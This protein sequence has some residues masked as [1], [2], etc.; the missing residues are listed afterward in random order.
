MRNASTRTVL[1]A[2]VF[3]VLVPGTVAGL[4]P[5]WLIRARRQWFTLTDLIPPA[6]GWIL[7]GFGILIY[8]W[9]AGTFTFLGRG[10]PSPTHPPE[11][12]VVRGLY[13]ISRNPMYV[14]VTL[15]LFGE[16][17]AFGSGNQ[18]VYAIAVLAAFHIRVVAAEEPALRGMFGEDY[19]KYCA[20]VPRWLGIRSFRMNLGA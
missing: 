4:A 1:G 13:R 11:K 18:L 2:I 9:C 17:F 16:A 10:T 12:L 6:V 5:Y 8:F 7:I 15:V 19:D 3:T 20:R 14:G